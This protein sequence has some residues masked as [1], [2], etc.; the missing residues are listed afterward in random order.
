MGSYQ[1]G[2]RLE[3]GGILKEGQQG[4]MLGTPV[5]PFYL[6]YFG[7]SLFKQNSGKKGTLIIKGL[8]GNLVC[9][10]FVTLEPPALGFL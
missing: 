10:I 4:Y 6:F 7:V 2:I 3:G 8:L 5:V 1:V 9:V